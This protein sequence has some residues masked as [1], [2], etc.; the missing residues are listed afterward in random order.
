M[1]ETASARPLMGFGAPCFIA[2]EVGVNHNGDLDM[3]ERMIEAAAAAGAD[4]VKF[5]NYRTEDF[6]TD[7]GLLLEYRSMGQNVSEPQYDLFKRCELDREGL[8]RLARCCTDHGVLF[9]STPTS[10]ETLDDLIAL[11]VPLL[12][13][14]SDYLGHLPLIR[15]M[16][17]SGIPTVLSTGMAT[18]GEIDDAVR[19]F[20][21]AGGR[22]LVLLHCTS[23]YPTPPHDVH[24]RKIP[25]LAAAFG[26]PAGFS[27]HTEGMAAAL[28]AVALGACM[29]EKHFT[30]D[31]GLPG[32][33]HWFSST[34]EELGQLVRGIRNLE[35]NLGET[36]IGPTPSETR[37]RRDFRLSCAAARDLPPGHV[38]APQDIVFRRPGTG[39]PPAAAQ[40]LF[41]SRLGPAVLRGHIFAREDFS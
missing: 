14:G 27:D 34:P 31:R 6:V 35:L 3:A 37:G 19:A 32:P 33:D 24:L 13:N 25:A 10:R 7:K 23:S 41:G 30:L 1:H 16:G 26:C 21:E 2:A 17:H 28:G 5:Q 18:L 40:W 9:F 39:L 11:N 29:V 38:L 15:D 4:A 36:A 20:R 12:K 8:A 22:D